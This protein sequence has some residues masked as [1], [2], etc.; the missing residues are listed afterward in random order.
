[1][2]KSTCNLQV[3][4]NFIIMDSLQ[5]N[6]HLGNQSADPKLYMQVT[7]IDQYMFMDIV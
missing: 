7:I 4:S 5:S 2:T 6:L 1:M 3:V